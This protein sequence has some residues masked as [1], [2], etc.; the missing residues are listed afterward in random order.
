MPKLQHIVHHDRKVMLM[1]A[2]YITFSSQEAEG[3]ECSWSACFLL[4][5][6]VLMVLLI[7]RVDL[8][9]LMSLIKIIPHRHGQGLN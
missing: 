9:T 2:S 4:M 6:L 8:L 1:G 7:F 5:H 3:D